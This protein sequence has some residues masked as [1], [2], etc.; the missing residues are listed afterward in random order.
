M[1]MDVTVKKTTLSIAQGPQE[2][3][4]RPAALLVV[5]DKNLLRDGLNVLKQKLP[6]KNKKMH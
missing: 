1:L 2:I 3:K 4:R 6:V 5:S